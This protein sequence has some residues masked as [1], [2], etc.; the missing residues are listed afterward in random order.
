M[1]AATVHAEPGVTLT[2]IVIGESAAFSG[3]AQALGTTCAPRALAY[4]QA[5][6]AAGGVNGRRI[7]L[8]ALDDGYEPE[9]GGQYQ[10]ADRRRRLLLFDTSA[11]DVQ[12][13]SHLHL[14]ACCSSAF[15]GAESLRNP[16]N[17]YI[18]N[19]RASYFDE[20]EKI[21]GQLVGQTLDRI[22]VFWSER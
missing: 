5:I 7:E 17:R 10:E 22:A 3:P 14:R 20:T 1:I 12:C 18:F 16:L 19:V 4:F 9:R 15:T 21:V 2:T 8:R 13:S 6:N 11:P